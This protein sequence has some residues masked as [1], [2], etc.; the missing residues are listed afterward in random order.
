M[1]TMH[2]IELMSDK[3]SADF[4][5]SGREKAGQRRMVIEVKQSK[6]PATKMTF[7]KLNSLSIQYP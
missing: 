7:P 6:Y 4:T 3:Y 2:S 1:K 5:Y